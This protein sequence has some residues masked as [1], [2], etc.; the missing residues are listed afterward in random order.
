[1][2][3]DRQGVR[4]GAMS[5]RL[6]AAE[7]DQSVRDYVDGLKA[8]I[9]GNLDWNLTTRRYRVSDCLVEA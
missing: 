8:W 6:L 1:M 5:D 3:A 4:R 7:Q 9:R 2:G